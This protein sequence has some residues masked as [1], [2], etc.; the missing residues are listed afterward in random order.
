[1]RVLLIVVAGALPRQPARPPAATP[2]AFPRPGPPN[3]RRSSPASARLRLPPDAW[4]AG[5]EVSGTALALRAPPTATAAATRRASIAVDWSG[6]S[7]PS[8][9]CGAADGCRAVRRRRQRRADDLQAGDLV[10][11]TT[12][13]AA[14]HTSGSSSAGTFVH[15]RSSSGVVRVERLGIDLL[16]V[17]IP[18]TPPSRYWRTEASADASRRI[19]GSSLC[20]R[21][22]GARPRQAPERRP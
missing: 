19:D 16:G 1:M 13:E 11:F 22:R 20:V 2:R 9:A 18:R 17:A 3:R 21:L 6:K 14:P 8:T 15:A 10:F 5:H 4:S 12:A 7:S